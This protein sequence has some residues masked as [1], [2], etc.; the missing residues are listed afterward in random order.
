MNDDTV[1]SRMDEENHPNAHHSAVA[2]TSTFSHFYPETSTLRSS[3][4]SS[5]CHSNQDQVLCCKIRTIS[6]GNVLQTSPVLL[7]TM[8]WGWQECLEEHFLP[9]LHPAEVLPFPPPTQGMPLWPRNWLSKEQLALTLQQQ[10]QQPA[11][12]AEAPDFSKGRR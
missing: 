7:G 6:N 9:T 12:V 11:S 8:Q 3:K 2:L 1:F 4:C 5:P 10:G